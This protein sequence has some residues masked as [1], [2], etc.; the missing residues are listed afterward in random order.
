MF[1]IK[2]A[3]LRFPKEILAQLRVPAD[4]GKFI[5]SWRNGRFIQ[6]EPTLIRPPNVERVIPLSYLDRMVEFADLVERHNAT[7][8]IL[9][10]TLLGLLLMII[11]EIIQIFQKGWHRE[12]SL[13]PHTFDIDFG[14]FH[15]E[16]SECVLSYSL[17]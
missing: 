8:F 13:I 15:E 11:D 14:I 9:S 16:H 4:M 5:R 6:C 1:K 10:G 2:G 3:S 12:C 17:H 7:A